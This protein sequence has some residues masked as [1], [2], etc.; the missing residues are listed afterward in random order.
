LRLPLPHPGQILVRQGAQR[1]NAVACGRRWGKTLLG[2]TLAAEPA[3]AGQPVGWFTP[4]YKMVLETWRELNQ[5]L[6]PVIQRSNAS[7]LRIELVTGGVIEVW[8]LDNV[9]AGRGRKY[10]RV[11]IDEAGLVAHLERAW[12]DSIRPTLMDLVG[13]AWLFSTPKGHNFFWQLW[14]QGQRGGDYASWQRPTT[15]NPYIPAAEIAAAQATLP[16]RTFRQE[17]LAEFLDDAG[18]V[19]RRVMEA[20]TAQGQGAAQTITQEGAGED[21]PP[22]YRQYI[23]G[24]DVAA[25]R[26]FTV[27]CVL[28]VA[29]ASLVYMDRFNRVDYT[30]L[31]ERLHAVY[32]RF[33]VSN[34]IVEANSIGQ[35]V[36]DHL[37]GRGMVITPFTTTGATKDAAIRL[38]Q[39]ALEHGKIRILPNPVLI[40]ELQAFEARRNPSGSF[41]YSAPEGLHDDCVMALALAW[42]GLAT[43]GFDVSLF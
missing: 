35:P 36:I 19:F 17:I 21:K 20:A 22:V 5:R 18:G 12:Q 1:Y 26:D 31:E 32:E 30:V 43:P 42:Q 16:E 27:V 13:D 8:S 4:T 2:C 38:L 29:D 6:H 28:D 39:A 3:I 40:S 33:Q 25:L 37:R 24:V 10:A 7:E 9:D 34:M 14:L 11:I 23:A 15:D 41:S